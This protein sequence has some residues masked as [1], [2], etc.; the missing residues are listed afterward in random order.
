MTPGAGSR[1]GLAPG[2]CA[3]I[4]SRLPVADPGVLAGDEDHPH[5]ELLALLRLGLEA[6]AVVDA[7][8]LDVV[9][10]ARADHAAEDAERSPVR[11]AAPL[12]AA[13]IAERD[14]VALLHAQVDRV[15][16]GD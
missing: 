16:R 7:A 13:D 4:R 5:Q 1:R 12:V 3:R 6:V 9:V 14:E 10:G 15:V 8:G 11:I 2:V